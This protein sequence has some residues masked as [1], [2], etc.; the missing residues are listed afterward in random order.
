MKETILNIYLVINSGIVKE[1]RAIAYDEEGSDD[2]KIAFLKSRAKED[3]ERSVHFDAP[4]DKNGNFMS[5][6][7]FYK[8]EKRGLQFQ[9]FEEIFEAFKVP[10]KPLVCV[11]PVVDGEIYSQ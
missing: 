7:K 6:N 9:L 10:D 4:T 1:F 8:L 3:F 2:E 5:Y 11:T